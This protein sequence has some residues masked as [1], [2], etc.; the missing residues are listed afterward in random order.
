MIEKLH[1]QLSVWYVLA[2]SSDLL[3]T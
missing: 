1:H 3:F 2:I